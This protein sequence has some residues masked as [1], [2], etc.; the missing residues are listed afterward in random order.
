[1]QMFSR[2]KLV[3]LS[4]VLMMTLGSGIAEA[5]YDA[6]VNW[7]KIEAGKGLDA[8]SRN[9][10]SRATAIYTPN[11]CKTPLRDYLNYDD[12]NHVPK[13]I[14]ITGYFAL[15]RR[16]IHAP[17]VDWK[18]VDGAVKYQLI[19]TQSKK[20]LGVT[21]ADESPARASNGW[22]KTEPGKAGLI[23]QAFNAKGERIALSRMFPFYVAMDFN[24]KNASRQKRPYREAARAAFNAILEMK[25]PNAPKEGPAAKIWPQAILVG[26]RDGGSSSPVLHDWIFMDMIEAMMKMADEPLRQ[27]LLQ[28]ARGVGDHILLSR[29]PVEGYACG[30]LVVGAV[31]TDCKPVFGGIAGIQKR[32]VVE[33]AKNGYAGEALVKVYEQTQEGKYLDAAVLLAEKLVSTQLEDGS[34]PARVDGKTGEI[35]AAYSTSVAAVVSFLDRLNDHKPDSRWEKSR[36][37]AIDWI[38]KYPMKTHGW[39]IN[40]DDVSATATRDEPYRGESFS[41]VDLLYYIRYLCRHPEMLKKMLP[42]IKEQLEWNDNHFVFYGPDPLLNFNPFYPCCAEQGKPQ[43]YDGE[44]AWNPMDF[45]TANWG[46]CMVK[47]YEATHEKIFLKKAKA[48]ANT[49]TQDQYDNGGTMTWMCDRNF[50]VLPSVMSTYD[51][52]IFYPSSW[53]WSAALWSELT[54][55]ENK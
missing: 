39:V 8:V 37:R 22:N 6:N 28:F 29:L 33:P 1:M 26:V 9:S 38:T 31:D 20:I 16:Y 5:D 2:T 30:N 15:C 45:H 34:W 7:S 12:Y 36:D 51:Y 3:G 43:F 23:I 21:D 10:D 40:F 11:T 17:K 44:G 53:A 50:G 19:L 49:L 4:W 27:K 46:L 35:I 48:A 52:A 47:L 18:P 32:E 42:E 13:A 55:L 25:V 54:A 41:N 14:E 24:S